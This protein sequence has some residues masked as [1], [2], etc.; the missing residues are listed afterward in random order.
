MSPF[1]QCVQ[2]LYTRNDYSWLENFYE[3]VSG[4]ALLSIL[5]KDEGIL[6]VL[7]RAIRYLYI[8]DNQC[9]LIYLHSIIPKRYK[10]PWIKYYR[11][12]KEDKIDRLHNRIRKYFGYSECEYMYIKK[13]VS[14]FI[15][16]DLQKYYQQFGIE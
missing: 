3:G 10:A 14:I 15:T 1:Y 2:N 9:L 16:K 8:L 4:I 7:K 11:K 5:G 12:P 13:N 6:S